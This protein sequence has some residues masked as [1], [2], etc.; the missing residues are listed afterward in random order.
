[1]KYLSP[2]YYLIMLLLLAA[3]TEEQPDDTPPTDVMPPATETPATAY[4]L[5]GI[6]L[7]TGADVLIDSFV[8]VMGLYSDARRGGIRVFSGDEASG[9]AYR[10]DA[11]RFA[12]VDSVVGKPFQA[13]AA[14]TNEAINARTAV[15][16]A[17]RQLVQAMAELSAGEVANLIPETVREG[18]WSLARLDA[19]TRSDEQTRLVALPPDGGDAI[20]LDEATALPPE[21]NRP[22]VSTKGDRLA[23]FIADGSYPSRTL[24]I[25]SLTDDVKQLSTIEAD[26]RYGFTLLD[27]GKSVAY[28]ND[29]KLYVRNLVSGEA[30]VITN[31]IARDT[32]I[33]GTNKLLA[34]SYAGICGAVYD[35][36]TRQVV[37]K[38]CLP[39]TDLQHSVD[40]ASGLLITGARSSGKVYLVR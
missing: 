7:A 4:E 40:A 13:F 16:R 10:F 35:I 30:R 5:D 29:G 28:I 1:M 2:A 32:D 17:Q 24:G 20:R 11:Q 39:D 22:V 23:F 36:G 9:T 34:W 8:E 38:Y 31:L 19:P 25:Y 3:C 27:E 21:A 12:R 37:H 33:A 15:P 14:E 6:R 26:G 18:G